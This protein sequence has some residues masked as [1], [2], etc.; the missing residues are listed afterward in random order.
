MYNI[1]GAS[2]AYISLAFSIINILSPVA[3]YLRDLKYTRFR[4]LKCGTIFTI[5][6]T[7][8]ILSTCS[9]Q[10]FV[11]TTNSPHNAGLRYFLIS[12]I[13]VIIT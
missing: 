10:I 8:I 12:A 6:A 11:R 2:G 9:S 13:F 5:A 4:L 1:K 7:G 3:G